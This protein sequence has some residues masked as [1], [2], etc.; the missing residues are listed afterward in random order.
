M[1]GDLAIQAENLSSPQCN[2]DDLAHIRN[3]SA[4]SP[5]SVC[6]ISLSFKLFGINLFALRFF[7]AACS[8]LFFIFTY[9]IAK[10]FLSGQSAAISVI[11][12]FGAE[13]WNFLSRQ[14]NPEL[15]SLCFA[16][17]SFWA[18][19][20]VTEKNTLKA[21]LFPLLIFVLSFLLCF[22]TNIKAGFLP[23]L[24]LIPLFFSKGQR[25]NGTL[26]L[27][28]SSLLI[29][30]LF[31]LN[32]NIFH[33]P[34]RNIFESIEINALPLIAKNLFFNISKLIVDNPTSVLPLLF[35]LIFIANKKKFNL[36]KNLEMQLI[37][38]WAIASYLIACIFAF[39]KESWNA[40]YIFPIIIFTVFLI[41]NFSTF[42]KTNA[43]KSLAISFLITSALWSALIL[44]RVSIIQFLF[45]KK[46]LSSLSLYLIILFTLV[47]IIP[48]LLT[49]KSEL[50]LKKFFNMAFYF[51][52]YL[53]ILKAVFFHSFIP[54][55]N[56]AGAQ[57]VAAHIQRTKPKQF[58]YL[59]HKNS[60]ADSINS[61]LSWYLRQADSCF[62]GEKSI[63]SI[64][65]NKEKFVLKEVIDLNKFR[66]DIIVYY[67]S[68]NLQLLNS[69]ASE[70]AQTRD[71][72][73]VTKSYLVFSK[74][75]KSPTNYVYI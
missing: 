43:Q 46:E 12:L 63:I 57:A 32:F 8:I 4:P 29:A 70:L 23:V 54:N 74:V 33:F 11:L 22:L 48:F 69:V 1:E 52:L 73:L 40:Y 64:P 13:S 58:I 6:L 71:M 68:E 18:I 50:F 47:F 3:L 27:L 16:L 26:L 21:K 66:D 62:E 37:I 72:L 31:L 45:E 55:K 9:L 24:F 44:F 2:F 75:V 53:I 34:A 19:L 49:K 35:P 65:L 38:F 36:P 15:P 10:R 39:Q 25:A 59:Y 56:I 60:P 5:I 67:F 51:S 28:S 61:Q 7:T 30:I 17:I 42:F 41:E 14:A 20:K